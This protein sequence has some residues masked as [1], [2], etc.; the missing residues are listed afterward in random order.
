MSQFPPPAANNPQDPNAQFPPQPGEPM[1]P[2]PYQPPT[3]YQPANPHEAP[4][5]YIPAFQQPEMPAPAEHPFPPAPGFSEPT[6]FQGGNEFPPT[7]GQFG[8]VD[9]G[10]SLTPPEPERKSKSKGWLVT[11]IV[12][13]LALGLGAG[14]GFF[15]WSD[16]DAVTS[17]ESLTK[18][19]KELEGK[20]ETAN[21]EIETLK[22]G[23][24]DEQADLDSQRADLLQQQKDLET[25][26][27]DLQTQQQEFEKAKKES[28]TAETPPGEKENTEVIAEGRWTVGDDIAPG[29]Y[30]STSPV[31]ADNCYWAITKSGSNGDDIVS[32]DFGIK[33]NQ[34]VVLKEGQDFES[35]NCGTWTKQ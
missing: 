26:Q 31:E 17:V 8:P 14:A 7:P 21:A 12:G 13:V 22:T 1:P 32:N 23:V 19:N 2:A 24:T 35:S 27:A 9:N 20:L 18:T 33:G 6:A 25:A 3:P 29:T 11:L 16:A 10:P 30:K 4:T 34:T 5:A 15:L 28:E